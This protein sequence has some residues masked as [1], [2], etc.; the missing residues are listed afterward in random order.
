MESALLFFILAEIGLFFS[1]FIL[2]KLGSNIGAT[3]IFIGVGGLLLAF[4]F[5]RTKFSHLSQYGY[6]SRYKRKRD[7]RIGAHAKDF[8][9][10]AGVEEFYFCENCGFEVLISIKQCPECGG[11]MRE[12]KP[13]DI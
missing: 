7:A 12:I 10:S 9:P 5:V 4:I 3:L 8:K 1:G 6:N 13:T 11:P 2:A